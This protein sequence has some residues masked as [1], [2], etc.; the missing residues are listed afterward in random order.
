MNEITID[1]EALAREIVER[2]RGMGSDAELADALVVSAGNPQLARELERRGWEVVLAKA[3]RGTIDVGK[4][5]PPGIDRTAA[6]W[7]ITDS[8]AGRE[9]LRKDLNIK[10]LNIFP[11]LKKEKKKETGK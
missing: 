6:A 8:D 3:R 1:I 7:R 11:V 2:N 9:R 5:V 4:R 10:D